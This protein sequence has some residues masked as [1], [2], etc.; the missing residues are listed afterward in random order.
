MANTAAAFLNEAAKHVG[1][2]GR[3]NIFTR[4]YARRHGS[5]FLAVAWCAMFVT[6]CARVAKAL[7]AL[8]G[9]DRA[10]T[11]WEAEDFE[12]I[13]RYKTGTVENIKRHAYQGCVVFFDW[14]GTNNTGAIDHVGIIKKVRSDGRIITVE[15]NT[16]DMVAIRLRSADVIAGFGMPEFD[17]APAPKPIGNAWPYK[18]DTVMGMGWENSA[19]VEKV[20]K[21]INALG[22]H[23]K[24]AEDGDFGAKT[25]A[26]VRWVQARLHVTVDGVV[27]RTET[28]PA[29]FMLSGK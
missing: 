18:R 10:Y 15:G 26:G 28:W 29:L 12:R 19:G 11:V 4:D 14:N 6:Y 9:G 8:P 1:T 23:P 17:K 22:Y 25:R 13:K 24:L 5:A 21:R 2:R 20:Q 7:A 27:G 16:S 3:P